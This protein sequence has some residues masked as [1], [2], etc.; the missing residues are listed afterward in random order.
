[1]KEK[2]AKPKSGTLGERKKI[3][4]SMKQA[5][6]FWGVPVSVQKIAKAAGCEAFVEHR[7]H[8]DPLLAWIEDNPDSGKEGDDGSTTEE[9][10]RQKL[11]EEVKI[12]RL[13]A[14]REDGL[15]IAR[16]DARND[17]A[18]ALSAIQEEARNMITD[19]DRY[20]IFCER[21]KS[22]IGTMTHD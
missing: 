1:M 8:R 18:R 21:I 11:R 22:R 3:A 16:E 14:A 13:K 5:Q 20:R 4:Q 2:T 17:W 10:K 12:L 19:D 15:S 6:A 9:L 7:V